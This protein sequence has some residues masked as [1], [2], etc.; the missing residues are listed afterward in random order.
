M[1]EE[2]KKVKKE[3][4]IFGIR[5]NN[6]S[7]IYLILSLVFFQLQKIHKV[8]DK[9]HKAQE[10]ADFNGG[11]QESVNVKFVGVVCER[12]REKERERAR[13]RIQEIFNLNQIYIQI[14]L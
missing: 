3:L 2:V 14:H 12:E 9:V 13:E 1:T 6:I 11:I 10:E 7:S 5:N 8:E 4:W